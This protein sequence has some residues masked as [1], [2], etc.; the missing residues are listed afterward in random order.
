MGVMTAG[1]LDAPLDA[2]PA[3]LPDPASIPPSAWCWP[4]RWASRRASLTWTVSTWIGNGLLVPAMSRHM[5][6]GGDR[7]GM[8]VDDSRRL[9]ATARLLHPNRDYCE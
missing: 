6:R 7:P 4:T 3:G 1:T 2:R 5:T 8:T 9:S